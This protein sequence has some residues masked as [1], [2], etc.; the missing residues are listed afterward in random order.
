MKRRGKYLESARSILEYLATVADSQTS[1]SGTLIKLF[2]I[3]KSS[4]SNVFEEME[5]AGFITKQR[6]FNKK[7]LIKL[8]EEGKQEYY[9][10]YKD[11]KFPVPPVVKRY[12]YNKGIRQEKLLPIQTDFISRGLIYSSRNVCIFGYPGTGKTLV[13]EMAMAKALDEGGKVLY[14]TPY[15]ALDS[16][17]HSDFQKSFALFKKDVIVADGDSYAGQDSLSKAGIIIS[18]YE[19]ILMAI[20]AR[21]PW[22][23]KLTLI[24]ADEITLLAEKG[25]GGTLDLV[26]TRLKELPQKPRIITISSLVG[27]ALEISGWFDAE[28]LI[29]NKP[30]F[31]VPIEESIVYTKGGKLFL[32][33]KNGAIDE[34]DIKGT[35]FES[36]VGRNLEL[37]KTTLVFISIKPAVEKVARSLVKIHKLDAELDQLAKSKL[38][39]LKERTTKAAELCEMIGHGIAYHHAGLQKELRRFVEQLIHEGRL[40][41]VVATSTLSHGIDYKIDSVV[42]DVMSFDMVKDEKLA[43][44]EYINLKGRT[45]RIG[46][47]ESADVYIL[48]GI[49]NPEE[50]FNRYFQS[51]PEKIY[52]TTTLE[53]AN[54]ESLLLSSSGVNPITVSEFLSK[55]FEHTHDPRKA[56]STNMALEQLKK[57][58][59]VKETK[60]GLIVTDLG[61][62]VN[63][64]NLSVE[65]A[66]R[67]MRSGKDSGTLL[68]TATDIDICKKLGLSKDLA[69]K[70]V[71]GLKLWARGKSIDEIRESIGFFYDQ[72]IIDLASYA[73][74]SLKKMSILLEDKTTRGRIGRLRKSI[75]RR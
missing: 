27:N 72:E 64:S 62:R 15:K 16:Q 37:G 42:V 40:R 59:L 31:A 48:A 55:T 8:T 49:I 10:K 19:K 17:K 5:E 75:Q 35:T 7:L 56:I 38:R 4:A 14:C 6:W 68:G 69:T 41:T 51:S 58:R 20:K 43:M 71:E 47:S 2:R 12:L 54:V 73:S 61:R 22:L 44:Y 30:A 63:D 66:C 23:E 65:D 25:R 57:L 32:Q 21:E 45:G 53:K 11:Q 18:T 24:C 9:S 1:D 74:L 60:D 28:P 39:G 29:E 13:A 52:P 46:K 70:K 26:L 3:P 50:I 67:V 33:R 34:I 36:L